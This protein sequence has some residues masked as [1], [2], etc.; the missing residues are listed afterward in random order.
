MGSQNKIKDSEEEITKYKKQYKGPYI[1][2]DKLDGVS[3]LIVYKRNTADKNKFDIK[4]YTRGNGTYG[5]DISHL[6][7]YI[8][9]FP[10]LSNIIGDYLAIRGELIISKDNWENS[11]LK[12]KMGQIQEILYPEQLTQKLSIKKY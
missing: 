5:Q 11:R 4:L 8:N 10:N 2:S 3:C 1:I 12:E 6:L 9:G 7:T